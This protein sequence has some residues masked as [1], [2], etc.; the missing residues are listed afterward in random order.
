MNDKKENSG[1]GVADHRSLSIGLRKS[2]RVEWNL[3]AW[4]R[5][6]RQQ[7]PISITD[8]CSLCRLLSPNR[9]QEIQIEYDGVYRSKVRLL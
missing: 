6:I 2:Q 3:H 8:K 7:V 4:Q 5:R 9:A 1:L